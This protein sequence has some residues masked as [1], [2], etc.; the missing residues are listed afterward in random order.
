MYFDHLEE[1]E[2]VK[3]AAL[4]E[5]NGRTFY[6]LLAENTDD[7]SARA[8]FKR[9]AGDETKHL[10]LIESKFFPEAGYT[11][12]ITD[13]EIALEDYIEKTG[14]ADIFTK[15]IDVAALVRLIDHPRKALIVALDTERHSV[16][17]FTELGEKAGSEEARTIYKELAEE[18][19]SHVRHIEDLLKAAPPF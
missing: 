11:D 6:T 7:E 5:E 19:R 10:K 4:I 8:V 13:E 2:A 12:Q 3:K 18:E 17:F 9:L 1:K 14:G 16:E 15:R